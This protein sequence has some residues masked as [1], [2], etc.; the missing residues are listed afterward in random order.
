MYQKIDFIGSALG[1]TRKQILRKLYTEL[2]DAHDI[3]LNEYQYKYCYTHNLE[4]TKLYTMNAI[5]A[6]QQLK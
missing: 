3:D 1:L 5:E 4:N 2:Q 6:N